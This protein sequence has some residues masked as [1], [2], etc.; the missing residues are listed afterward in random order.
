MVLMNTVLLEKV[1]NRQDLSFEE[2]KAWMLS[3]MN[4][5]RTPV[6]ITALIVALRM[7]SEAVEEIAGFASVMREKALPLKHQHSTLVDTC[8]TGGDHSGTFNISTISAFVVAGSGIPVAKHGNIAV[9]SKCGSADLLKALGINIQCAIERMQEALNE[10]GICFLFA[11]LYHEAMKHAAAP[12]KE[13]GIRTIFNLLGPLSNP[14]KANIQ[15][16]GV[17]QKDLTEKLAEVLKQLR[18]EHAVVLHGEGGLDEAT[19]TGKT[20]MSELHHGQITHKIIS[21]EEF[22][23]PRAQKEEILG[24]DIDQNKKIALDILNG[25]L[26]P[27][28]DIVALNAGL[29]IYTAGFAKTL[30]D[31]INLAFLSLSE[32]KALEKMKQLAKITGMK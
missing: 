18:V 11:P 22:D 17:Y 29:A 14:A 16:L 32:G 15:I 3:M 27:M 20:W 21:P 9:S 13:M 23:L 8:G 5:E 6:E 24:G 2:A 19:I 28:A 30:K 4:G 26:G 31:G 7:K 25:K 1:M 10:V 12:R